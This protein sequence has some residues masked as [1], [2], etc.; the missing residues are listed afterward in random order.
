MSRR[1]LDIIVENRIREAVEEGK[2][3]NLP[4]IGQPIPD[5]DEPY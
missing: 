4:G 3:D 1:A 5:I 2:F